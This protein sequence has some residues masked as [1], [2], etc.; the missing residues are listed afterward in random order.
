MTGDLAPN[1]G[2]QVPL[3]PGRF[4][5]VSGSQV[6]QKAAFLN[7]PYAYGVVERTFSEHNASALST[8]SISNYNTLPQDLQRGA[9]KRAY[10]QALLAQTGGNHEDGSNRNFSCQSCHM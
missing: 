9:I 4:S 6:T 10:E 1:N 2:A 5:G 8:T 7:P 3:P